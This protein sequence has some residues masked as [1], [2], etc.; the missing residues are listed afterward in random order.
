MQLVY[1]LLFGTIGAVL[2]Y[3]GYPLIPVLVVT[4][5]LYFSV[6]ALHKMAT[7]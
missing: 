4:Q 1:G 5:V 2:T 3:R 7:K 6:V